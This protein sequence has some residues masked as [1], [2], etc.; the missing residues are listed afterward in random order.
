MMGQSARQDA[1]VG[2]GLQICMEHWKKQNKKNSLHDSQAVGLMMN[3]E[4]KPHSVL[5]EACC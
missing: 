3:L 4:N 1:K 2:N 5:R